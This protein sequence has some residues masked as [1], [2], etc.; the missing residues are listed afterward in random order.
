MIADCVIGGVDTHGAFHHAVV[1]DRIGRRLADKEFAAN[2]SGYSSMLAWIRSHGTLE[3][4]GVEGTGAYGAG[5]ARYLHRA[6]IKVIE[7]A[8]PDRRIR[9]QFGK[10]DPIDA[11]AA[12]R[13][14]LAG[15]ASTTPKL[16]HGIVESIRMLR[17]TR[18]GAMKART[19]ALNTLRALLLT[20]PDPL[21]SQLSGLSQSNLVNVC[22]RLRPDMTCLNDP[23][24]GAKAS[25]R[26]VAERNAYSGESDQSFRSFRS[27]RRRRPHER[28]T[29]GWFQPLMLTSSS[30]VW[31]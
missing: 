21:R 11:E 17:V 3:V 4:V 2:E 12:A 10:S 31:V 26:S 16:A 29:R 18:T 13:A 24:N 14:V 1:L 6:G 28:P 8:R 25:L 27:P 9:R 22:R 19:A 5:L 15:T 30:L 23:T 7:V 20:A